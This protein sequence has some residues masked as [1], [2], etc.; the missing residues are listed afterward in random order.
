MMIIWWIVIFIFFTLTKISIEQST[1]TRTTSTTTSECENWGKLLSI[2]FRLNR[3]H[4]SHCATDETSVFV[5][6][7]RTDILI[8]I[9]PLSSNT[10]VDVMVIATQTGYTTPFPHVT[11]PVTRQQ[12]VIQ[13]LHGVDKQLLVLSVLLSYSHRK[14]IPYQ[15]WT[16]FKLCR[17]RH[18]AAG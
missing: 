15:R 6:V 10:Q 8:G 7:L 18:C 2:F 3:N 5:M 14:I 12:I 17:T 1:T 13:W 16:E 9:K 11:V 4:P